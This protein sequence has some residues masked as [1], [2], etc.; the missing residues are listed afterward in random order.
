MA[1]TCYFAKIYLDGKGVK[2]PRFQNN[3]QSR[4]F[5][6]HFKKK[7]PDTTEL[8]VWNMKQSRAAVTKEIIDKYYR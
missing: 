1:H 3:Y 4:K 8:F 5:V 6:Y 7:H 2:E